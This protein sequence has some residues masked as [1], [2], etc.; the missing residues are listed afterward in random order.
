M[1]SFCIDP[2]CTLSLP[3]NRPWYLESSYSVAVP[4]CNSVI[5]VFQGFSLQREKS[6]NHYHRGNGVNYTEENFLSE[7]FVAVK[8][9]IKPNGPYRVEPADGI[10][11][12]GAD[13][14][15]FDLTR[16]EEHT[17]ELQ[18]YSF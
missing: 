12:Y 8:I 1:T 16:S 7:D 9:T 5:S 3:K 6:Q 17:S 18:S 2:S 4:L 10:E 15:K 11:L 13:G 14:S